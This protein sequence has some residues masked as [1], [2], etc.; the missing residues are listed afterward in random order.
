[1]WSM[2]PKLAYAWRIFL[3]AMLGSHIWESRCRAVAEPY[4]MRVCMSEDGDEENKTVGERN[5]AWG[6]NN[7]TF[8][9]FEER[10]IEQEHVDD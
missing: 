9:S 1:M 4:C 8:N 7:E 3:G 10:G 5:L 2:I 6:F